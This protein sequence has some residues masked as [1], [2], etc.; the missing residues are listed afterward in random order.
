[1][2]NRWI[3]LRQFI[4]YLIVLFLLLVFCS[5][6]AGE[7]ER[8]GAS[9]RLSSDTIP[10][11]RFRSQPVPE[12]VATG[13]RDMSSPGAYLAVYW[14]ESRFGEL[15]CKVSLQEALQLQRK[16]EKT[17]E[18]ND[19][20]SA[21]QSIWD[22]LT[23]FPVAGSGGNCSVSFEDS[24]MYERTYKGERGHEG[25]DIMPDVLKGVCRQ[26]GLTKWVSLLH[27]FLTER[28]GL[29]SDRLPYPETAA[30]TQPL[31][32]IIWRGGNFG[33]QTYRLTRPTL[34]HKIQTAEAFR[35]NISFAFRYAPKEA[36]AIFVNLL[37]GQ[38]R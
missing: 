25:T 31:L 29:A 26:A 16:W 35:R 38:I 11:V 32:E 4:Q 34:L 7:L 23:Y 30:N 22:D 5:C 27:A 17:D 28:L 10:D 37:K 21:C 6:Q 20:L 3:I 33:H 19:Y 13:I 24:W 14:V 1:M 18:W 2:K 8:L 12:A 9:C 15:D 36:L